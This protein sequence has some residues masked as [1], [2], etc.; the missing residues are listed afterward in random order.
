MLT[1]YSI[2]LLYY[3][4]T[5]YY[6]VKKEEEKSLKID[7]NLRHDQYGKVLM[8][9]SKAGAEIALIVKEFMKI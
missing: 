1:L 3:I 2:L 5:L 9:L 4:I 8:E 7:K 6:L